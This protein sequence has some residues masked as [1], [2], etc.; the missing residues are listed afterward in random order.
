MIA[1]K[2]H[3]GAKSPRGPL[4]RILDDLKD[5]SHA[6]YCAIGDGHGCRRRRASARVP[7]DTD[8]VAVCHGGKDQAC[9][10]GFFGHGRISVGDEYRSGVW[11]YAREGMSNNLR[12]RPVRKCVIGIDSLITDC[13][14]RHRNERHS[15]GKGGHDRCSDLHGLSSC[16]V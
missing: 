7:D 10:Y 6:Q 9:D 11:W 3:P 2:N 14:G 1:S 16:I 8:G 5:V 12:G 4:L 15:S 13:L